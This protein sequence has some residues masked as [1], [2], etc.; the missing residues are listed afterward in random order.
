MM[1]ELVQ[2]IQVDN[3]SGIIMLAILYIVIGFGVFG[4][5]MM[6]ISERKKEFGILVSV[7]MK[8]RRLIWVTTLET[9]F[10]SFIGVIIGIIGSIPIVQYFV[11]HPLRITGDASR[12]FDQLGIEPIFSFSNDPTIYFTQATV[13]LIIALASAIYPI[14]Y[15]RKLEPV[16]AL[17]A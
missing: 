16:E 12:T 3:A 14:L 8:K 13:V 10:V 11:H 4:T 5:V 6:M 1:P 9:I 17:R 7:G 2:N 15:I